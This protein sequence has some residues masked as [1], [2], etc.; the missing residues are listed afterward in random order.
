MLARDGVVRS[1]LFSGYEGSGERILVYHRLLVWLGA[2]AV[3]GLGFGLVQLRVVSV[4]ATTALLAAM[5][6]C[7][8]GRRSLDAAGPAALLL[9]MPLFF[10]FGIYFRPEALL[11]LSAWCGYCIL[12]AAVRKGSRTLS[13]AAGLVAGLGILAHLN[14]IAFVAGGAAALLSTGSGRLLPCFLASAA[15]TAGLPHLEILV[16]PGLFLR[17]FSGE[18]LRTKTAWTSF[19]P[20]TNLLR[21]HERLFR[22]PG[23]ALVTLAVAAA[24]LNRPGQR[25]AEK[26]LFYPFALASLLALA[27]LTSSKTAKYAVPLM[28]FA[29]DEIWASFE[30]LPAAGTQG[31]LRKVAAAALVALCALLA[32]WGI[33]SAAKLASGPRQ[34]LSAENAELGS[35]IPCGAVCVAPMSFIFDEAERL[36]IHGLYLAGIVYG[37]DLTASELRGFALERGAGFIVLDSGGSAAPGVVPSDL[38]V[39]VGG[40]GRVLRVMPE[41]LPEGPTAP[42]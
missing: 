35:A 3:S 37:Q 25:H 15:L 4:A 5:L 18:L 20:F 22:E 42:P 2:L 11:A 10:R 13:A 23:T 30:S 39:P 16:D 9:C 36:E 8:Q 31:G 17:Q 38:L 33:Y 26:P 41:D 14:G 28:P 40:G 29:A 7:R 21:E 34:N 1:D 6:L 27:T 19:T 32:A 12:C 24:L